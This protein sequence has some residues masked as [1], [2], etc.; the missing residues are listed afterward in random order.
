[1]VD[2][3]EDERA[4][5]DVMIQL[6]WASSVSWDRQDWSL[7]WTDL[8]RSKF[9][10]FMDQI[11]ACGHPWTPHQ[12]AFI[13]DNL[14]YLGIKSRTARERLEA[15]F[16]AELR[17][18]PLKVV[19]NWNGTRTARVFVDGEHE[20]MADFVMANNV[21]EVRIYKGDRSGDGWWSRLPPGALSRLN[22]KE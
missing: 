11:R 9:S 13:E 2:R 10:D 12:L 16:S 8:G 14:Y 19:I 18:Q 20:Q 3:Y 1:M 17:H 6:G 15:D 7:L 5:S 4:F 21:D 22:E